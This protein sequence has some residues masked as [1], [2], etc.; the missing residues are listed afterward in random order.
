MKKLPLPVFDTLEQINA[1][2]IEKAKQSDIDHKDF[3]KALAF[4]KC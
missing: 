1:L 4:L 3:K 2:D